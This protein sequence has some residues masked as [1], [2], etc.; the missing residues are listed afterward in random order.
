M[1]GK[2]LCW[3]FLAWCASGLQAQ[4]F[5]TWAS[6][7]PMGWNSWD[8]FGPTVTEQEV[9]A[10]ADYMADHLKNSGWQYIVVDIR[11]YV[12]NDKAHGYNEKDP[13]MRMDEYGRLIP[14]VNRFPSSAGGRGFKPLADYVHGPGLK[15]GIHIMRGIPRLAVER[16]TPIFGAKRTAREIYS[17][18]NPCLWLRDMYTV[19]CNKS[20]AQEYYNS[21]FALYASWGVDFV[22]VDDIASPYHKDEIE[23]IRNAIDQCGRPIVLSLSPGPTPLE[24]PA[25]QDSCQHVAHYRRLLGQLDAA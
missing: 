15:F 14:A 6:T 11:W 3:I 1:M 4:D 2:F 10:N 25:C 13:V 5:G 9:K 21:I 16:N 7:P 23:M 12:E 19:D 18:E 24:E 20:G 17:S 8:C 22:K